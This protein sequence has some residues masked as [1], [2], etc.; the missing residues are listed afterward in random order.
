MMLLWCY[1]D[2]SVLLVW[3]CFSLRVT[4]VWCEFYISVLSVLGVY[5]L[6]CD[7]QRTVEVRRLC[8]GISTCMVTVL[9]HCGVSVC[10]CGVSVVSV[11]FT[12]LSVYSLLGASVVF[13]W[14]QCNVCTASV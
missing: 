2:V 4:L 9:C 3:C 14:R 10:Q 11:W 1:C 6:Q 12:L 7:P 8:S 5:A 13:A